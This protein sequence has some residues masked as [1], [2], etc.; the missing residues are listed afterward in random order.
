MARPT[1]KLKLSDRPI[2]HEVVAIVRGWLDARLM[3]HH[4]P[5][6]VRMYAA[7]LKGDPGVLNEYFP[8][9]GR[10]GW[11]AP[12]PLPVAPSEGIKVEVSEVSEDDAFAQFAG[13]FGEVDFG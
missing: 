4:L 8:W 9:L 11:V 7:L 10:G 12:V 1:L 3:S 5:R 13:A 6:A 2:A